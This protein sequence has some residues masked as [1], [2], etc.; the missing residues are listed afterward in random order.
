VCWLLSM[1]IGFDV[2]VLFCDALLDARNDCRFLPYTSQGHEG[3]TTS[4]AN[5]LQL[6]TSEWK[7]RREGGGR[8]R[9]D[10]AGRGRIRFAGDYLL[11][12]LDIRK[13][14]WR[15]LC[16]CVRGGVKP[17]RAQLLCVR[18]YVGVWFVKRGVGQGWG[19]LD[20]SIHF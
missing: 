13:R 20:Q 11:G 3:S 2:F 12:I 19:S 9:K 4:T 18:C 5:A 1:C 17:S 10:G 8:K 16:E 14:S 6:R 7:G 15:M